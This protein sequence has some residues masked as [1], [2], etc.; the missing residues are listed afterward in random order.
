VGIFQG[1]TL[2]EVIEARPRKEGGRKFPF[3]GMVESTSLVHGTFVTQDLLGPVLLD[4]ARRQ[5]VE[6]WF[7]M[8]CMSV[9]Q[10]NESATAPPRDRRMAE[11]LLYEQTS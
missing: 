9:E 5:G 10:N 7:Y 8:E 6:V 4:D 1:T 2:K 3:S 11:N